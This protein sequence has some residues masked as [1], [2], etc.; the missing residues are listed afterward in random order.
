MKLQSVRQ[1]TNKK[2]NASFQHL[3][4]GIGYFM[5][6]FVSLT[7]LQSKILDSSTVRFSSP[8]LQCPA[9]YPDSKVLAEGDTEN[10]NYRNSVRFSCRSHNQILSGLPEIIC[11]EQGEWSGPIPTCKGTT[12]WRHTVTLHLLG[13]CVPTFAWLLSFWWSWNYFS[14]SRS[15]FNWYKKH[16][17]HLFWLKKPTDICWVTA[18]DWEIRLGSLQV[19]G[20]Y[21]PQQK[22]NVPGRIFQMDI[23]LGMSSASTRKMTSCIMS[24]TPDMR[25][26]KPGYQNVPIL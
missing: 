14:L 22:L 2:K 18:L 23:F 4:D 11:N 3:Y 24:A 25:K 12:A 19:I 9:I 5:V 20:F 21:L 15:Q 26:R 6:L 17:F 1:W 13:I 7:L 16:F 10:A 8:A